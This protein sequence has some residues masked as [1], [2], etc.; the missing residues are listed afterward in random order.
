MRRCCGSRRD[1]VAQKEILRLRGRLEM[2][3][4]SGGSGGNVIAQEEKRRCDGSGG[5]M[6]AQEEMC[7]LRRKYGGSGGNVVAHEEK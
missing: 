3:R 6:E 1:V 7:W 2:V 5:E 4:R